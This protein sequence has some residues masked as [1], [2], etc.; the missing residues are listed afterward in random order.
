M[1][2]SKRGPTL[3]VLNAQIAALQAQ[4]DALFKKEVA[5][6]IAKVG[7]AIVHYGLTA[8]DPN[9]GNAAG[10]VGKSPA[11]DSSKPARKGRKNATAKTTAKAVKFKDNQGHTWGGIGKRPEWLK[12]ALASGK[13]P[14][15]FLDKG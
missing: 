3:A 2:T 1:A 10:N 12:A 5:E 14:E 6:V 11:A 4:A 8:A 13:T 7:D 9:F 15:Y